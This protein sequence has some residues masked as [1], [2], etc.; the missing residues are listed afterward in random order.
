[1]DR[2]QP[3]NCI[4]WTFELGADEA[5]VEQSLLRKVHLPHAAQA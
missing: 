2:A 5:L 1:L 3:L 4:L